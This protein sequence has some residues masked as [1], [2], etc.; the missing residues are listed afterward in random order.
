MHS[1]LIWLLL[2]QATNF[3]YLLES[4]Q[5][6]LFIC[7]QLLHTFVQPPILLLFSILCAAVVKNF[8]M[9]SKGLVHNIGCPAT[10]SFV[11]LYTVCSC[12][13]EFSHVQQGPGP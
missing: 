6:P 9:C 3:F 5:H 12:S 11:V 4:R 10:Y 1:L 7:L 2:V 13:Q 8:H